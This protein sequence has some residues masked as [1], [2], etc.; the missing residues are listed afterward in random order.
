[1][2]IDAIRL[3]LPGCSRLRID[4]FSGWPDPPEGSDVARYR[5]P[6]DRV[7]RSRQPPLARVRELFGLN[8]GEIAELFG[9][10]R[11][12][13]EQ[14]A[15]NGDVPPAR[16]EKLANLLSVGELLERKLS[17]GCLSLVARRRA[18]V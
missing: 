8:T 10:K 14:W 6:V 15:Q 7:L 16:R 11:Q 5:R 3:L 18:D 13:V 12:A 2:A 4:V 9:V 1:M 17:P